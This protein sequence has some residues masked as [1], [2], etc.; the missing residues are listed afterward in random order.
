[1]LL[2]KLA[3]FFRGYFFGAHGIFLI[4]Y[5]SKI[6]SINIGNNSVAKDHKQN[7]FKSKSKSLRLLP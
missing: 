1:M 4:G 6:K 3:K 5:V 7:E 2:E